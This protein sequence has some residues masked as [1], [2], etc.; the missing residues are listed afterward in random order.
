MTRL[1]A[2]DVAWLELESGRPPIATGLVCVLEPPTLPVAALRE[3]VL[4]R[5]PAM[6]SLRWVVSPATRRRRPEWVDAGSPDLEHH[7]RVSPVPTGHDPLG[8][9][10]SQ[11]M[12]QPM[13]RDRPL[14][15][16]TLAHGLPDGTAVLVW[17]WHHALADGQGAQAMLGQLLDVDPS[18][19]RR[20]AD[21]LPLLRPNASGQHD[22]AGL[23]RAM[24][25]AV[26]GAVDGLVTTA[27]HLP[28]AA[29]LV[30]D[31]TPRP[32]GPLTGPLS[33][34]R[35]WVHTTADVEVA[36]QRARTLGLSINDVL[37]A[38]VAH[39]LGALL[40]SRGE[41]SDRVLRCVM[42][43]SLRAAS[44]E[45]LEN[46][47][48]AAWVEL[49]VG[50]MPFEQRARRV[51][52]TTSWQK[53]VG[54]PAVGAA[55]LALTDRFVPAAVQQAVVTHAR[56][57]PAWMADT[58]VTNVPGAPFPLFVAGRRVPRAY[59]L[60]PA[61]GH[62]RVLVG[63]VSHAGTLCFGVTGD[64]E[65]AADVHVA[66]DGIAAALSA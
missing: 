17:R 51:A 44:D 61:D 50:P 6:P 3:Q 32:P 22:P 62:L 41:S 24:A 19:A 59:P 39:G 34:R 4:A 40:E 12:E 20:L 65:H 37:L 1:H 29:R 8:E 36:K 35:R 47:V 43:V 10:V 45:R 53:H 31:L 25:S 60:I 28:D 23:R 57:V 5:L 64:G 48:S 49:P 46:K 66:R 63:V 54:T 56:W 26:E 2:L 33:S 27:R 16:M 7:V 18:G 11:V 21:V 9:L 52:R 14:W 13:R 55:L 15:D 42:P 58:L 38:A 30:G